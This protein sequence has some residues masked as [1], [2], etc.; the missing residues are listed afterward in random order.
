[1]YVSGP[2]SSFWFEFHLECTE[3]TEY[4][5]LFEF[6]DFTPLGKMLCMSLYAPKNVILLSEILSSEKEINSKRITLYVYSQ[7]F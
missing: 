4:D 7:N 5:T 1:M 3:R 2:Q 6:L